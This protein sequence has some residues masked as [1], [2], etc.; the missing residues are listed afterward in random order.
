MSDKQFLI[1]GGAGFLG[2]WLC[3]LLIAKNARVY[4]ID[5]LSSGRAENI[6][7]L[8]K[9]KSFVF[10]KHDIT[11]NTLNVKPDYIFHLASRP[12]PDDYLNNAIQTIDVN[13]EGT[14]K[15]LEL[16]RKTDAKLLFTSTSEVYGEATVFPTPENYYGN[17]NPSGPRSCYDESKRLCESLCMAYNRTYGLDLRIVRL[18]NTY[19]PRLRGDGNYG[20]ALSRFIWQSINN[21]RIT[22][23]GN[24]KQTR[25][26]CYIT[27]MINGL[28]GSLLVK[29]TKG[30]TINLGNPKETRIVDLANMV[31][32]LTDSKSKVKYLPMPDNDPRRRL[33]KITK[34]RQIIGFNPRVKL[35]Q[36]L[37]K[38]IEWQ[39]D[40]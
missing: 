12:S 35:N 18:F 6:K 10:K 3:D 30:E 5:N 14:K 23:W 21:Q 11:K 26:F 19:G 25:S 39:I 28:M 24:G 27:D 38:T 22:I 32:K 16:T 20:R 2:S 31:I 29:K 9:N 8:L 7:H 1:T 37:S 36:G 13:T 34:A 17:V 4:C 15:I 40:R 33:P